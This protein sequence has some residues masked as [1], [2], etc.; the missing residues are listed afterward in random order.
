MRRCSSGRVLEALY[1]NPRTP[2][3]VRQACP[4]ASRGWNKISIHAPHAGCDGGALR[5]AVLFVRFQSTHPMR[6]ATTSMDTT[7]FEWTYFNPRTPC[8]VR[9]RR[10]LNHRSKAYFNPRTPCGVRRFATWLAA[11]TARISI[12][13]PHAGCDVKH[14]KQTYQKLERFQSTH[15]MRGATLSRL[16]HRVSAAD[17]NPRTPCGVR[18]TN[19]DRTPHPD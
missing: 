6:G 13:A 15:P 19:K 8:G 9:L 11:S 3:G 4:P 1:F 12:H 5:L 14:T 18:L 7:R 16:A 2:C 17:F 10:S